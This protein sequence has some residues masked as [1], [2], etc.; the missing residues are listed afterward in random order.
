MTFTW[1]HDPEPPRNPDRDATNREF[2]R[3]TD[4][5]TERSADWVAWAAVIAAVMAVV[6]AKTGWI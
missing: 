2:A 1:T 5:E 4:A 3:V 6:L